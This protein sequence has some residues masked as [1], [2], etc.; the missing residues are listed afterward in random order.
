MGEGAGSV[1]D[2]GEPCPGSSAD[3]STVASEVT[4]RGPWVAS[5]ATVL[6]VRS[7][8]AREVRVTVVC[9]VSLRG[10]CVVSLVVNS[11]VGLREAPVARVLVVREV[12]SGGLWVPET[13]ECLVV[14]IAGA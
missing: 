11:E 1:D 10:A 14:G 7:L 6:E 13:L 8:G 2:S 9:E 4:N 12:S 5:V 3:G